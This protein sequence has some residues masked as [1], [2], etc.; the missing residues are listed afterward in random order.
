MDKQ[1]AITRGRVAPSWQSTLLP[2]PPKRWVSSKGG[3]GSG[4]IEGR[5]EG[6]RR[7]GEALG[8]QPQRSRIRSVQEEEEEA[9]GVKTQ[10]RQG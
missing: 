1:A 6:G 2:P 3:R 4:A 7:M 8:A 9:R 10:E 5:W